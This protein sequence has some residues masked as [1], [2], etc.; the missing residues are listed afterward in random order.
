[1]PGQERNI[2]TLEDAFMYDEPSTS[3][4]RPINLPVSG[5][6]ITTFIGQNFGLSDY[7]PDGRIGPVYGAQHSVNPFAGWVEKTCNPTRWQSDSA[8]T[9]LTV[10]ML[11][12][13]REVRL[14]IGKVV[15]TTTNIISFDSPQISSLHPSNSMGNVLSLKMLIHGKHFGSQ[16]VDST[17]VYTEEHIRLRGVRLGQTACFSSA[18]VSDTSISCNLIKA[19]IGA[20]SRIMITA[21]GSLGSVSHVLSFDVPAMSVSTGNSPA[22]HAMFLIARGN[23][24]G[25]FDSSVNLR[26]LDSAAEVTSWMSVTS[27]SAAVGAG[28]RQ[29]QLLQITAGGLIGSITNV[30]SF[31]L[32]ILSTIKLEGNK[33][34]VA[35]FG[36]SNTMSMSGANFGQATYSSRSNIAS[37]VCESSTWSSESAIAGIIASSIPKGSRN[38][39]MTIGET[40]STATSL[41]SF[42]CLSVRAVSSNSSSNTITYVEHQGTRVVVLGQG[43]GSVI[44][45]TVSARIGFTSAGQTIWTSQTAIIC[46]QSSGLNVFH[47]I[48]VTAG[49]AL[50]SISLSFTYDIATLSSV[51]GNTPAIGSSVNLLTGN[52]LASQDASSAARYGHTSCQGT[53]WKSDT[54]ISCNSAPGI[55]KTQIV[56]VTLGVRRNTISQSVSYDGTVPHLA[57]SNYPPVQSLVL[58][59]HNC[60]NVTCIGGNCNKTNVTCI[61]GNCNKTNCSHWEYN[62]LTSTNM[63]T[64]FT[65]KVSGTEFGSTLYSVQ[66]R[67]GRTGHEFTVWT[68]SSSLT[69]RPSSGRGG[70][71]RI[72]VTA[73]KQTGKTATNVASYHVPEMSALTGSNRILPGGP[74]LNL[75]GLFLGSSDVSVGARQGASSCAMSIWLSDS[76]VACRTLAG[77]SESKRQTATAALQTRTNTDTFSYNRLLV[78]EMS[79]GNSAVRRKMFISVVSPGALHAKVDFS[80]LLRLDGTRAE[81]SSWIST[82]EILCR[83]SMAIPSSP[84]LLSQV[85]VVT[86]GLQAGSLSKSHTFDAP[87]LSSLTQPNSPLVG[88]AVFSVIGV[89][90]G[91]SSFSHFARSAMTACEASVWISDTAILS[92][93]PAGVAASHTFVELSVVMLV[94]TVTG[95]FT[96]DTPSTSSASQFNLAGI[97]ASRSFLALGNFAETSYTSR[98]KS[99]TAAEQSMW[100]STSSTSVQTPRGL[101]RSIRFSVTTGIRVSTTSSMISFDNPLVLIQESPVI[102]TNTPATGS[103]LLTV[104]GVNFGSRLH[105]S[106]VRVAASSTEF[107][108]WISDS[109]V[110]CQSVAGFSHTGSILVTAG[111]H[112]QSTISAVSWDISIL[113]SMAARNVPPIPWAANVIGAPQVFGRNFGSLAYSASVRVGQTAVNEIVWLSDSTLWCKVSHGLRAT[114][115]TTI[116]CLIGLASATKGISYDA[117]KNFAILQVNVPNTGSVRALIF[118][119]A[120]GQVDVTDAARISASACEQSGWTSNSIVMCRTPAGTATWSG[121]PHSV[122]LTAAEQSASVSS[123]FTYLAPSLSGSKLPNGPWKFGNLITLLGQAFSTS[124]RSHT[125]RIGHTTVEATKWESESSVKCT[126]QGGV[127]SSWRVGITMGVYQSSSSETYSYDLPLQTQI[128]YD[129]P[130]QTEM[131]M[132][133]NRPTEISLPITLL[134]S[135]FASRESTV[136]GRPGITA[137]ERSLWF[138]YSS[139]VCKGSPQGKSSQMVQVTGSH[140]IGT[141]SRVYSF[142]GAILSHV[143]PSNRPGQD[144]SSATIQGFMFG[145]LHFT[146]SGRVSFVG[147][148][149]EASDWVSVSSLRCQKAGHQNAGASLG[150]ILT[151]AGIAGSLSD[152]WSYDRH[153]ILRAL[154]AGNLAS[155]GA[156]LVTIVGFNYGFGIRGVSFA[157]RVAPTNCEKTLWI[158]DSTISCRSSGG[159]SQSRSMVS[160]AGNQIGSLTQSITFESSVIGTKSGANLASTGAISMLIQG[161]G[162]ILNSFSARARV[163]SSAVE[164]TEWTSDSQ[165]TSQVAANC[166]GSLRIGITAQQSAKTLTFVHSYNVPDISIGVPICTKTIVTTCSALHPF[167][168]TGSFRNISMVGAIFPVA[169]L[170]HIAGFTNF[171]T[172]P[173]VVTWQ[174]TAE[175]LTSY[176]VIEQG[177]CPPHINSTLSQI[178]CT[179]QLVLPCSLDEQTPRIFKNALGVRNLPSP[180]CCGSEIVLTGS[181]FGSTAQMTSALRAGETSNERTHWISDTSIWIKVA[182]ASGSISSLKVVITA[183]VFRTETK[184]ERERGRTT[185]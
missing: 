44:P 28:S 176:I 107:T 120:L 20:T 182:T 100:V 76:S 116:T 29:S 126:V 144:S 8:V 72:Q 99:G 158:S 94:S 63:S 130:L 141:L 117:P 3:I 153:I 165:I 184:N 2:I 83:L 170:V 169:N 88:G 57:R 61:G 118:G 103:V 10:S 115:P 80:L 149:C 146:R 87:N 14:D 77:I 64:N 65:V 177:R 21:A 98:L 136:S 162:F 74:V 62:V 106:S 178:Q 34:N 59:L 151:S 131:I 52:Q 110:A 172:S 47:S 95:V 7:S 101:G 104:H 17:I 96:Y 18:W 157:G 38:V 12:N 123:L 92:K 50:E 40:S 150:L 179:A 39:R 36:G 171:D 137:A 183:Q 19:S 108:K 25:E 53:N 37:S 54:S 185:K 26:V 145:P 163:G 78:S 16:V 4:V 89:N 73:G 119:I 22:A 156:S 45:F 55:G 97:S 93:S 48:R 58:L 91:P 81:Q 84:N 124:S 133:G 127:G 105:S 13:F 113:S 85:V 24:L 164:R 71:L 125:G 5:G 56:K 51:I 155:T 60:I 147:S 82:D 23:A 135:G 154:R 114:L 109:Y 167:Q 128:R 148:A 30:F 121:M 32:P 159:A 33:R 42:D 122:V 86:A 1:V 143:Q 174:S 70:S 112:A 46:R 79:A 90:F 9:C 69:T 102:R 75:Q 175:A 41:L 160:T 15:G 168:C 111:R 129:L 6:T 181:G 35:I 152:A 139:L 138:S 66:V 161:S 49:V 31:D 27:V 173:C 140:S 166:A 180:R 11:G 132:L 134:G 142:D 43:L 67:G 68:S